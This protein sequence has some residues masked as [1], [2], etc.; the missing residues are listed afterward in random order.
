MEET[1]NSSS[2]TGSRSIE[3]STFENPMK[4][5]YIR[6]LFITAFTLVFAVCILGKYMTSY[7]VKGPA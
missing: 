3:E 4:V 5:G 6:D 7:A 1:S 2:P